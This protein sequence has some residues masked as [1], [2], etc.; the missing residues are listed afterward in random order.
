MQAHQTKT[1]SVDN[2]KE[3]PPPVTPW[4]W[5]PKTGEEQALAL[6][7]L[8]LILMLIAFVLLYHQEYRQEDKD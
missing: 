8:G 6:I 3:P 1:I 2:Q 5:I 7:V 4:D